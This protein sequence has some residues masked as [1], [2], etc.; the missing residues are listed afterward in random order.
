MQRQ[1]INYGRVPAQCHQDADTAASTRSHQGGV[2]SAR[3]VIK[4]EGILLLVQLLSLSRCEQ[5]R[6][7]LVSSTR[8]LKL[9]SCSCATTMTAM[10]QSPATDSFKLAGSQLAETYNKL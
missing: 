1:Q 6:L 4:L 10:D 5:A 9:R 2:D 3:V 7:V 8:H